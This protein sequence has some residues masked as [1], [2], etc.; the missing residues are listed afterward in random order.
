MC[1]CVCVCLCVC[2][3]FRRVRA[4]PFASVFIRVL[5]KTIC[6]C[7]CD[8]LQGVR[9][10]DA[11][12][13]TLLSKFEHASSALDAVFAEDDRRCFSSGLDHSIVMHDVATGAS[14][15]LGS[16]DKGARC[17]EYSSELGV[18]ISGSW[19]KT[20]SLWDPRSSTGTLHVF[21]S[22]LSVFMTSPTSLFDISRLIL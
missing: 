14:T 12:S 10:H 20:V 5:S 6:V 2:V 21:A 11:A 15:L 3:C 4:L 16:H 22:Y 17:V 18:V 1:V 8:C 7:M 19:D 9:I 13:N